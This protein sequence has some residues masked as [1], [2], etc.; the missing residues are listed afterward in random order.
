MYPPRRVYSFFPLPPIFIPLTLPHAGTTQSLSST[1]EAQLPTH[2][3]G[4]LQVPLA[5]T[6]CAPRAGLQD[7]HPAL[8][9]VGPTL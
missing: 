3:A 4:C 6:D 2:H 7:F 9:R 1:P 8:S 5:V